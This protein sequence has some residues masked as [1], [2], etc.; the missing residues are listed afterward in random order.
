[1]QWKYEVSEENLGAILRENSV[2]SEEVLPV[3]KLPSN[4]ILETY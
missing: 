2:V 4:S 3:K 1:M